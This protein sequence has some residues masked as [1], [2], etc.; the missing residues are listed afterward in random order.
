MSPFARSFD[1]AQYDPKHYER[2]LEIQCEMT[3]DDGD[4]VD[5]YETHHQ[6]ETRRSL[7]V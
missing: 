1:T 7:F 2:G 5:D 6:F 3:V 4:F